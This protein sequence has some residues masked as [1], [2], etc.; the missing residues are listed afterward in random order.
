MRLAG[1]FSRRIR[2]YAQAKG[3]PVVDCRAGERK[4]IFGGRIPGEDHCH[5]GAIF[6]FGR[7][8]PGTRV[9]RQRQ[10]S[11]R[12]EKAPPVF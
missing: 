5:S 4:L 8:R 3:I 11:H 1:R 9:G 10:P 2:G 6:D 12:A 7:P